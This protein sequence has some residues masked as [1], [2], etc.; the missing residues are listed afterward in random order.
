MSGGDPTQGFQPHGLI[1]IQVDHAGHWSAQLLDVDVHSSLAALDGLRT[2]LVAD[3]ERLHAEGG[4]DRSLV[5]AL[6]GSQRSRR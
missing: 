3:H 2:A 1:V 4:H 6:M 5:A